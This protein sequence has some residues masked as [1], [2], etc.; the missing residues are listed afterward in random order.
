MQRRASKQRFTIKEFL[1]PSGEKAFRVSGYQLSGDRVRENFPTYSE[2]L[3]R[4]QELEIGHENDRTALTPRATTL[5]DVQIRDAERAITDL[6][7]SKTLL[8]AVRYYRENYHEPVRPTLIEDARDQFI[9][10]KEQANRRP[11]TIR[12]LRQR[13]GR[14]IQKRG[15][16]LVSE[17][18]ADDIKLALYGT[19][20][21][22]ADNYR[23]AWS[24][25]FRWCIRNGFCSGNPLEAVERPKIERGEVQIMDNAEVIGLLD[26][27]RKHFN[28]E[29][30]PYVTLF[31]FGGLRHTEIK[32][33]KWSKID[34]EDGSIRVDDSAAKTRQRRII[35]MPRTGR[36]QPNLL[37]WLEPFRL[38]RKPFIG[39]NWRTRFDTV[40][41]AA[42][43]GPGGQPWVQDILRHTAISNHLAA[44]QHEGRTATWAGNSPNMIHRHYKGLVK[45][46]EAEVF[47]SLKPTRSNV[48][49]MR[50]AA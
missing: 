45:A 18:R 12:N 33:L 34:F 5:T 23:R 9:K 15:G 36:K 41:E 46:K 4:Q 43:W 40:K 11:D 19:S 31:V 25:F 50:E 49:Q 29:L 37:A 2:A 22:D 32:R 38:K 8:D 48:I 7:E 47:W 1:N 17:I 44:G 14:L 20:P 26:A 21:T 13:I 30:V 24:N 16:A 42:G 6:P 28:G 3:A 39:T 35:E 10:E 27:A